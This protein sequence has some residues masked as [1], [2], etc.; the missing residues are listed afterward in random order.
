M[1][2][3]MRLSTFAM[4][5]LSL[6]L[7]SNTAKENEQGLDTAGDLS[8]STCK[9][10]GGDVLEVHVLSLVALLA[11]TELLDDALL[12]SLLVE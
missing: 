2:A 5:S 11:G 7:L 8:T 9:N 3:P 6:K 4:A 10:L 12:A 1:S